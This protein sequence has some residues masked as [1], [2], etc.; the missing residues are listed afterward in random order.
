MRALVTGSAGFVGRHTVARLVSDGWDVTGVDVAA[1][2]H[3]PHLTVFQQDVRSFLDTADATV[4]FDLVVHCAA[5]VGGRLM[6]DGQ[7]LLLAAED[8]SIDA[9]LFRWLLNQKGTPPKVVY[10]SSS[11]AYPVELQNET[12]AKMV[13][14]GRL[15]PGDLLLDED[16]I[17]LPSEADD[18]HVP[19]VLWPDQTYGWVKLTGERMAD[20]ARMMG[21]PVYVFRPFSGYG[22]DQDVSYPFPSFIDRGLDRPD[23]FHVW[24][25]GKQ[26]RDFVHISDVVGAVMARIEGDDCAPVNIGTGVAT[27]FDELAAMTIAASRDFFD[28]DW[29]PPIVHLGDKPSG[30]AWRVA[31]T[32][33]L[34]SFYVPQVPLE[35]GVRAALSG[36][37]YSDPF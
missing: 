15:K 11:A 5:V 31:E 4:G 1:S 20:E 28:C 7:P 18:G 6:I 13:R 3:G 23:V 8:L 9:A 14:E 26:V 19:E 32:S 17:E 29:D 33:R 21:L 22:G 30:V 12:L 37:F 24:G 10:F 25:D 27:S 35:A 34:R 2:A 16:Q 36:R